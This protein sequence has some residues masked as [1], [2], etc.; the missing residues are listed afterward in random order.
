[1]Q[2]H[3]HFRVDDLDTAEQTALTLGAT[4]FDHQP[5]TTTRVLADPAGHPFCL[6]G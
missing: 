1:M 3:L 2:V 4:R 5:N 6:C